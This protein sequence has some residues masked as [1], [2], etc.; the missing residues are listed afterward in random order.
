[1]EDRLQVRRG[2]HS[3]RERID[4][5]ALSHHATG[6][7]SQTADETATGTKKRTTF[8]DL[9]L[10]GANVLGQRLSIFWEGTDEGDMWYPGRVVE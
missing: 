6:H 7:L 4:A 8:A 10:H 9:N 5:T 3:P 1:M 2:S